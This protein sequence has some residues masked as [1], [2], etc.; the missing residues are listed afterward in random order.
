MSGNRM[1][2]DE[3]HWSMVAEFMNHPEADLARNLLES[4]GIRAAVWSDDCGGQALG[5][6][7]VQGV[8]VFVA[9][10]DRKRA[11]DILGKGAKDQ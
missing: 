3:S 1:A 5:Q 10:A 6:T 4:H 11:M 9:D 2:G 7:F 8:R